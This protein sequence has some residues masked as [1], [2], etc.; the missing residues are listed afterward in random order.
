[1]NL[2]ENLF[3]SRTST[4][5][6]QPGPNQPS[7]NNPPP[8][9]N[10]QSP[11]YRRPAPAM[12]RQGPRRL[13][14]TKIEQSNTRDQFVFANLAGVS[15]RDFPPNRD[16]TDPYILVNGQFVVVGRPNPAVA[17]GLIALTGPM[18]MWMQV[19][20]N[21]E[22]DAE[23]YDAFSTGGYS[24]LGALGMLNYRFLNG[25]YIRV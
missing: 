3:G 18:R 6:S 13:R 15:E 12:S 17:P 22:I 10:G 14:L 20:M 16:G 2:R 23:H 1:M 19:A 11:V 9:Y 25:R 5:G 8:S 21:D 24:Y 4:N 7:Y